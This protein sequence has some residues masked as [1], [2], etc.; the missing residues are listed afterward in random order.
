MSQKTIYSVLPFLR[1]RGGIK[2]GMGYEAA[3]EGQAIRYAEN[4]I[5]G[6]RIV[7]AV[8]ISQTGNPQLGDWEEPVILGVYGEVSDSA[9]ER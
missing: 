2:Q 8:A 4:R 9:F 1:D 5:D 6:K 3:S 7:G